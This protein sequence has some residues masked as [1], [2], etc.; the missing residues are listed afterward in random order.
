[1]QHIPLFQDQTVQRKFRVQLTRIAM[2]TGQNQH[3][4]ANVGL[5]EQLF[6]IV[7]LLFSDFRWAKPALFLFVIRMCLLEI[8]KKGTYFIFINF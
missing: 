1:M 5:L 8:N 6:I 7:D 4:I 3:V 2:I